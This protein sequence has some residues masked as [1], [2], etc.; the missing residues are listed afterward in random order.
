MAPLTT[1]LC[2][3]CGK[4][5]S[6]KFPRTKGECLSLGDVASDSLDLQPSDFQMRCCKRKVYSG[7]STVFLSLLLLAVGVGFPAAC[8]WR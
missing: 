2:T 1:D 3:K 7:F 8:F 4:S 5:Q 6:P